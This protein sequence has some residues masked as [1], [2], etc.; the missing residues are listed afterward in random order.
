MKVRTK[1]GFEFS[2]EGVKDGTFCGFCGAEHELITAYAEQ[3]CSCSFCGIKL[4][5]V[6]V[7]FSDGRNKYTFHDDVVFIEHL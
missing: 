2:K 1:D 5:R 6:G 3:L 4:Q 7:I